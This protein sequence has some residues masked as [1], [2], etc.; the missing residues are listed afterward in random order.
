MHLKECVLTPWKH[1]QLIV[2][3]VKRDVVGRYKGSAL[4]ILWSLFH[5]IFMLIVYTFVFSVVFKAKWS[6]DSDSKTEFALVLFS[7]LI[8]FNLFAECI[9][10]APVTITTN[11]NYVKKIIF[12]LEILPWVNLGSAFFHA[13][14]SCFV[15]CVFYIF[16]FGVPHITI[17][18]VPVVLLPLALFTLGLSWFLASLG[19]Y[20]RDV[21]QIVGLFVTVLM[22]L[23]PIF[24]PV[25]ALPAKYQFLI[26][27]NPLAVYIEEAR[28]LLIWGQLPEL[29]TYIRSFFVSTVVFVA[30][31]AWFQKTR[32][33]FS[34]VL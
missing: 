9:N 15:W 20:L 26:G 18:L 13:M 4:G 2:S 7:G 19:V 16:A 31:F 21:G 29:Q 33:G 11:V 5:P 32:D 6:P 17:L 12:P 10:R 30:G 8:V 1:R 27:L 34:D 22:F 28:G 3:M 14:I 23:S 25:A 24:Y